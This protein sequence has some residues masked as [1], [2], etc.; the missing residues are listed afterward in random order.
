MVG[1][2][3]CSVNIEEA[4]HTF[5]HSSITPWLGVYRPSVSVAF[6]AWRTENIGCFLR[7]CN[8]VELF[9]PVGFLPYMTSAKFSF[10]LQFFHISNWFLYHVFQATSLTSSAFHLPPS[11]F[12]TNVTYESP[13]VFCGAWENRCSCDGEWGLEGHAVMHCIYYVGAHAHFELRLGF[14]TLF[15]SLYFCW[16]KKCR[17]RENGNLSCKPIESAVTL[18]LV[19]TAN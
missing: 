17:H 14:L 7:C 8:V 18:V 10:P 13:L 5:V 3:F 12:R 9:I 19:A 1:S 11:P 2:S 15:S 6:F 16:S 4:S